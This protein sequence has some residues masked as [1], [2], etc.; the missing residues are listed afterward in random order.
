MKTI[1]PMQ[2]MPQHALPFITWL[3]VS[4]QK[5]LQEGQITILQ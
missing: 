1:E 3:M 5:I 2:G 4:L